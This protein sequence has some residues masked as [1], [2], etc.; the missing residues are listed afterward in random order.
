MLN[1]KPVLIYWFTIMTESK[2][3]K[4]INHD[5]L[6]QNILESTFTLDDV[7]VL[8]G[9]DIL[10]SAQRILPLTRDCEAWFNVNGFTPY[11]RQFK[12]IFSQL[13]YVDLVKCNYMAERIDMDEVTIYMRWLELLRCNQSFWRK[14]EYLARRGVVY[15]IDYRMESL[16]ASLCLLVKDQY[17]DPDEKW[18]EKIIN[19]TFNKS[20]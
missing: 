7:P 8:E 1:C 15:L 9:I 12:Q 11:R 14:K 19:D 20:Q 4:T 2:T 13:I 18:I 16:N 10:K 17:I 5:W 3:K 6:P